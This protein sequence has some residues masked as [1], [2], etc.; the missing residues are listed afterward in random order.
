LTKFGQIRNRHGDKEVRVANDYPD[1]FP[2]YPGE[3]LAGKVEKF[4]I[5]Q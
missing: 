3:S 5:V 2:L 4:L 1:P